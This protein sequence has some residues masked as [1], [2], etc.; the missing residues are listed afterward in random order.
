MPYDPIY[1]TFSKGGKYY[2]NV[3]HTVV[4]WGYSGREEDMTTKGNF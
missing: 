1:K 4:V 2:D 3:E